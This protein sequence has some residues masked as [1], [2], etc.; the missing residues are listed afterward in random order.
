MIYLLFSILI[1]VCMSLT[2]IL[3]QTVGTWKGTIDV[4]CIPQIYLN[5]CSNAIWKHSVIN[6]AVLQ[7]QGDYILN[8]LQFPRIFDVFAKFM[9]DKVTIYLYS[10]HC[11]FVALNCKT[12]QKNWCSKNVQYIIWCCHSSSQRSLTKKKWC[13]TA[14]IFYE[15]C[16]TMM[17]IKMHFSSK[18]M[19]SV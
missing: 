12:T 13:K 4:N 7:K 2:L 15:L 10:M 6:Y 17:T 14:F 19:F 8:L 9:W 1:K 5:P 18:Y 16:V 3:S 11:R